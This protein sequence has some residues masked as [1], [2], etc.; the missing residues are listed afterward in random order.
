MNAL[1]LAQVGPD[2]SVPLDGTGQYA[3]LKIAP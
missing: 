2:L 1:V 3:R